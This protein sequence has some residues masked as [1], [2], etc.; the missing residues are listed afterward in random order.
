MPHRSFRRISQQRLA[1]NVL[2]GV[3]LSVSLLARLQV[4]VW[5]VGRRRK[6]KCPLLPSIQPRKRK[7]WGWV[8]STVREV[9]H[10][11]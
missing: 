5:G 4:H 11:K 3:R 2:A 7:G 8:E 6:V 10:G 9:G 1:K